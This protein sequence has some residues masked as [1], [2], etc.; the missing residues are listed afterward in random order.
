MRHPFRFFS[1]TTLLLISVTGCP[2][3]TKVAI[4]PEG[5][6]KASKAPATV[7][8]SPSASATPKPVTSVQGLF[9]PSPGASPSVTPSTSPSPQSSPSGTP[10]LVPAPSASASVAG[11]VPETGLTTLTGAIKKEG[12]TVDG[13]A[14]VVRFNQI[15]AIAAATD[16]TMFVVDRTQVRRINTDGSVKTIAGALTAGNENGVGVTARFKIL[17]GIACTADGKTIYVADETD[18]TIRKVVLDTAASLEGTVTTLAGA[19]GAPGSSNGVGT[20]GTFNKPVGLALSPDESA[21]FVADQANH[22]IRKIDVSTQTVSTLAGSGTAGFKDDT[23]S[24][25]Q[26]DAPSGIA[27]ASNGDVYVA[28]T[29]NHRIRKITGAGVVTTLAGSPDRGLVNGTGTASSFNQPSDLAL[30]R[31]SGLLYVVDALN[32][33]IRRVNVADGAVTTTKK[34]NSLN[35]IAVVLKGPK[36]LVVAGNNDGRIQSLDLP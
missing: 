21:L 11:P 26:F 28:D 27:C 25:A 34:F 2:A 32:L 4:T 36:T 3:N 16:G 20:A 6:I 19:T 14:T 8:P 9:T 31:G 17:M 30:D 15:D 5:R 35:P 29:K 24:A 1:L 12:V 23:G 7:S 13:S 10:Q 22:L 33:A 18:H